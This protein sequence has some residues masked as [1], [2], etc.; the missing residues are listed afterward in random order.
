M[1]AEGKRVNAGQEI[2]LADIEADAGA[3][4]GLF[5]T[6]H[7][8]T[9]PAALATAIKDAA[10]THYGAVG[11]DWLHRIV[12]DRANLPDLLNEGI[13]R[14]TIAVVPADAAGQVARV[15]RRFALV[16]VAGELATCY[17]LSGWKEGEASDAVQACFRSWLDGFGGT[18]NREERALLKQVKAFF[19]AHGASRFENWN[20]TDEQRVLNRAGFFKAADEGRLFYVLPEAFANEI[21]KGFPAKW[22]AQTLLTAGWLDGGEGARAT[23]KPR[24]PG[25]GPTRCYAFNAR[26]WGGG[27]E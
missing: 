5:N 14:F 16:A 8:H 9:K 26:M 15:A 25:I 17:G 13:R 23:Q 27:D 6:L 18:G 12:N 11:K 21:C 3:G 1:A 22:A 7:E 10:D 19:E 24:L 4:H 20:A 2:R